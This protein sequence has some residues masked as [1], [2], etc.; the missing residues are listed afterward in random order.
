MT[1]GALALLVAILVGGTLGAI[2][3]FRQNSAVDYL[4]TGLGT[5]GLT[6]P[7]FVVAPVLQIVFGLTLSLA[8]GR[9]LDRRRWRNLILPV[10]T[11]ALPQIAVVAR[12]T[13]AAMIENLRS[14]HIRTL[15][16]LGLPNRVDRPARAARRR[17]AGRVLSRPGR[18]GAPDRVRR[19]R[20][21]LRACRA[22]GATSSRR[23]STATTRS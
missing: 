17:P 13:R 10:I 6:I 23:R 22:S 8:A 20:D 21:D 1:L 9:R 18:R 19:R 12:M 14:N 3:A 4:V 11:L 2:A 5:F 7:T 15:R 16:S